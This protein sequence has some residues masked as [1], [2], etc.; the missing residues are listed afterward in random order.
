MSSA[1][2]RGLRWFEIP[3]QT[4]DA[5]VREADEVVGRWISDGLLAEFKH[6]YREVGE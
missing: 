4:R 2:A 5:L 3:A 6:D 1:E